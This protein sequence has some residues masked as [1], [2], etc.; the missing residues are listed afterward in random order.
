M[1]DQEFL[2]LMEQ[3]D[4]DD[5][6]ALAELDYEKHGQDNTEQQQRLHKAL[7]ANLP[8]QDSKVP[9]L[10]SRRSKKWQRLGPLAVLLAAAAAIILWVRL[11]EPEISHKGS[12]LAVGSLH[13]ERQGD[14]VIFEIRGQAGQ[15]VALLAYSENHQ[16]DELLV[17]RL[18]SSDPLKVS[19]D[20]ERLQDK[21]CV[22]FSATEPGINFSVSQAARL[23][24]GLKPEQ[25]W[26]KP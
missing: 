26:Q 11:P 2:R 1:K 12:D 9:S 13:A 23:A 16:V 25:C 22:I 4:D 7:A 24:S 10:A 15:Y 14:R 5:F 6:V 20:F 3:M 21:V 19:Q 17:R 8:Q 18:E